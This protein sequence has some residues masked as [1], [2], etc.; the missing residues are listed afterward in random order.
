MTEKVVRKLNLLT[1]A[2]HTKIS[3]ALHKK[4][5]SA[6]DI[7]DKFGDAYPYCASCIYSTYEEGDE[8]EDFTVCR[9]YPLSVAVEQAY[10]CGE[11]LGEGNWS[12]SALKHLPSQN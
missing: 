6:A 3:D 11:Y 12:E 2:E 8:D 1:L 7:S 4:G 5:D 9:R 10:V